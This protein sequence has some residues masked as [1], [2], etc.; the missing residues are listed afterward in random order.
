MNER[1]VTNYPVQSTAFHCLLTSLILL[2][3]IAKKEKWRSKIIGQIHDSAIIDLDPAEQ[4]H[5]FKTCSYIMSEKMRELYPWITVPIPIEIECS[6]I[7][8]PWSRK[9]EIK[10]N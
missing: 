7:D 9:K 8:E 5:V 2:N 1:E 4:D 10:I 3:N 6:G